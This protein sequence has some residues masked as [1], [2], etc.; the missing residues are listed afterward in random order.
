VFQGV[1]M[2]FDEQPQNPWGE[3][4]RINKM[5]FIGPPLL[6]SRATGVLCS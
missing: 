5:V 6:L 1:H 2:M 3:E 4:E